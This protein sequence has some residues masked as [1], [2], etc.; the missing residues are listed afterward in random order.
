MEVAVEIGEAI[1]VERGRTSLRTK[2]ALM[3]KMEPYPQ[4]QRAVPMNIRPSRTTK[5]LTP[6]IVLVTVVILTAASI[7]G[8]VIMVLVLNSS[9]PHMLGEVVA[10]VFVL[11]AVSSLDLCM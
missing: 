2:I 3:G 6:G 1:V 7:A 4:L 8:V 10:Q 11:I 5:I 9:S